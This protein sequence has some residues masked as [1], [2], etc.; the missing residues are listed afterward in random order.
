MIV[1]DC[2]A[3]ILLDRRL[4]ARYAFARRLRTMS[5]NVDLKA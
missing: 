4:M 2:V 3:R 1:V 5:A